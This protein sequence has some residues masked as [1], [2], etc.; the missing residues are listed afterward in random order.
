[1]NE[2]VNP[3]AWRE[4]AAVADMHCR[5]AAKK[6]NVL[7]TKD[8]MDTDKML[9]E[10]GKAVECIEAAHEAA[11]RCYNDRLVMT[12]RAQSVRGVR[13]TSIRETPKPLTASI[14]QLSETKP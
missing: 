10:L 12:R 9:A 1:M 2:K 6:L 5:L 4:A 8:G 13:L 7:M 3:L 14:G 11:M